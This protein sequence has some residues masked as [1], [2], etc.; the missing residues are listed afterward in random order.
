[1]SEILRRNVS[2]PADVDRWLKAEAAR[3]LSS[4]NSELVRSVRQRMAREARE[5]GEAHHAV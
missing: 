5:Q 2:L 1:M 4:A 3:N